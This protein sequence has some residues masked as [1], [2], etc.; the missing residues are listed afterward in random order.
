M[1][2][3]HRGHCSA[4]CQAFHGAFRV[5][6][7]ALALQRRLGTALELLAQL[8]PGGAVAP[9]ALIPLLRA[10]AAAL[11]V[12]HLKLLHVQAAGCQASSPCGLLHITSTLLTHPRLAACMQHAGLQNANPAVHA[13]PRCAG[14][15]VPACAAAQG[16]DHGGAARRG[17]ATC[18]HC[19]GDAPRHGAGARRPAANPHRLITRAADAAG[20]LA[21]EL[22]PNL[23]ACHDIV[24][25]KRIVTCCGR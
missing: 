13:L 18:S 20:S 1:Q 3:E 16:R 5:P 15:C 17:A 14:R 21:Q 9:P 2:L 10:C 8:L 11:T 22:V 23:C 25:Y 24:P 12:S 6:E 7:A 4:C 19:Q